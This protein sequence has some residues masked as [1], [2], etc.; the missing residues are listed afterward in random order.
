MGVKAT[1]DRV[2]SFFIQ[3]TLPRFP[4]PSQTSIFDTNASSSAQHFLCISMDDRRV[5]ASAAEADFYKILYN[6]AHVARASFLPYEYRLDRGWLS[7]LL[8]PLIVEYRRPQNSQ[9]PLL[10]QF[11][12]KSTGDEETKQLRL[13]IIC[14]SRDYEADLY[15]DLTA[16]LSID[17]RHYSSH[18]G[19]PSSPAYNSM[20]IVQ[21]YVDPSLLGVNHRVIIED[22]QQILNSVIVQIANSNWVLLP[23]EETSASTRA[24]LSSAYQL[25]PEEGDEELFNDAID[26]PGQMLF[27]EAETSSEPYFIDS[28]IQRILN[29]YRARKQACQPQLSMY[30]DHSK[31]SVNIRTGNRG[32]FHPLLCFYDLNRT[33]KQ[34][35]RGGAAFCLNSSLTGVNEAGLK[36]WSFFLGLRPR[37][38]DA[39]KFTQKPVSQVSHLLFNEGAGQFNGLVDVDESQE[40]L[41]N[42]SFASLASS[43]STGKLKGDEGA[44]VAKVI[45]SF[46]PLSNTGRKAKR[47]EQGKEEFD[48]ENIPALS[49]FIGLRGQEYLVRVEFHSSDYGIVPCPFKYTDKNEFAPNFGLK[50]RLQFA[51]YVAFHPPEETKSIL[52]Q[53]GMLSSSTMTV[54]TKDDSDD[55]SEFMQSSCSSSSRHSSASL[56][57]SA[58]G[59]SSSRRITQETPEN[60]KMHRSIGPDLN[61]HQPV[62]LDTRALKSDDN[63]TRKT[64]YSVEEYL[65]NLESTQILSPIKAEDESGSNAVDYHDE[66]EEM[67]AIPFTLSDDEG[68]PNKRRKEN[69]D[70]DLDMSIDE[71]PYQKK[72]NSKKKK[73]NKKR[74]TGRR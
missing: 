6:Y 38:V 21:S 69:D 73:K 17:H 61:G 40:S 36:L 67:Q 10:K 25:E 19:A 54:D 26:L 62:T 55:S 49:A 71:V 24:R 11:T 5:A 42:A 28:R 52:R 48:T 29:T 34:A 2:Q 65:S 74:K 45:A 50:D 37:T 43:G 57:T 8:R 63:C 35:R 41:L 59:S 20:M 15:D 31:W 4:L 12:V 46:P 14:K 44:A 1:S 30:K 22:R 56:S 32:P 39:A 60:I 58:A 23:K 27:E 70:V 16:L 64:S 33:S 3:H 47:T 9:T 68:H 13:A 66:G 18:T 53:C 72:K 51:K 7:D